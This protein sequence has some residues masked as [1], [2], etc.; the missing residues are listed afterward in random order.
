MRF[1]YSAWM[2]NAAGRGYDQREYLPFGVSFE[3]NQSIFEE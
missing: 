2:A 3:S 1:G